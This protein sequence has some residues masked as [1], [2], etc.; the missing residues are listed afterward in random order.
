[1]DDAKRRQIKNLLVENIPIKGNKS[2]N[3]F[4]SYDWTINQNDLSFNNARNNDDL[5]SSADVFR[6]QSKSMMSNEAVNAIQNNDFINSGKKFSSYHYWILY[7]GTLTSRS[8]S[9]N[10]IDRLYIWGQEKEQKLQQM[11][12]TYINNYSFTPKINEVSKILIELDDPSKPNDTPNFEFEMTKPAETHVSVRSR[13]KS[14]TSRKSGRKTPNSYGRKMK[15]RTKDTDGCTF[16]PQLSQK[17]LKMAKRLGSSHERLTRPKKKFMKTRK[18]INNLAKE[19]TYK[20]LNSSGRSPGSLLQS[21]SFSHFSENYDPS[22][23]E[24]F[25]P[26]IN[27]KSRKIDRQVSKS[28]SGQSRFERLYQNKGEIFLN[29]L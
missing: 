6:D 1:M 3:M 9:P 2:G 7:L 29:H 26:T 25:K 24:S 27:H 16:R 15:S 22:M 4:A 11:K 28:P 21:R 13:N 12:D 8:K 5:K 17:S 10:V 14:K 18:S 23:S 19:H 20:Y